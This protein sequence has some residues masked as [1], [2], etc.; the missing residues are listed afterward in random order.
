[1]ESSLKLDFLSYILENLSF[2]SRD[3]NTV[4]VLDK[5]FLF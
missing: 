3:E 4:F 1:M 5:L 2:I